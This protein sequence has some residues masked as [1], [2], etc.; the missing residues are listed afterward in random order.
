MHV[1][2]SSGERKTEKERMYTMCYSYP[3]LNYHIFST[4][5]G[6]SLSY[7]VSFLPAKTGFFLLLPKVVLNNGAFKTFYHGYKP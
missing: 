6:F 3:Y 1:D 7:I 2:F 4:E 5:T